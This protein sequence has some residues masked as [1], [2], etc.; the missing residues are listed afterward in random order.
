MDRERRYVR[1][2]VGAVVA[3]AAYTAWLALGVG[4]DTGVLY[5]SDLGTVLS[6]FAAT[7][8]CVRAGTGQAGRLRRFWWLLGAACGAWAVGEAIW[9]VYDLVLRKEV[10]VPSLA[11]V[12]YLAGI[13]LAVAALLSHPAMRSSGTRSARA[14]VDGL[15]VA[16][17]VL[18]LSWTFL[19]GPLWESSDLTTAG[20]LVGLAYPFGDVVIVF[21]ILL[22]VRR[23]T[24]DGRRALW[25]LLGGLLA[26]ALA[27]SGYAYV[28]EVSGYVG[29]TLLDTGWVAGYL[30]IAVGAVC[31]DSRGRVSSRA[32]SS[33]GLASI[34]AGFLPPLA[35]LTVVGIQL[36]IGQRP[37]RVAVIMACVLVVVALVRQALLALELMTSREREGSPITRLYAT[38]I[39]GTLEDRADSAPSLS[40]DGSPL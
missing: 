14:L 31:S 40:P 39:G 6:A 26:T 29:G 11:D 30:A 34:L 38:L 5:V 21:F 17:A 20:G 36:Q 25:W 24:S 19:L 22:V 12:G 33:A 10:P 28:T 4:G 35:G 23:M 9:S 8:L 16:T 2:V 13:P 7:V 27:D 1:S 3:T 37:D 18:F 15:A 32:R